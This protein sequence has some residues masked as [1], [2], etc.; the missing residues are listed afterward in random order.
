V[1]RV[2]LA[3]GVLLDPEAEGPR[4]GALLLEDGRIAARLGPG[5]PG[6]GDA[7]RVDLG[8]RLLA[9]GF[10]DLHFHGS[11]VFAD[12]EGFDAA[13]RAD[14]ASLVRGGTTA[15]LVTTVAWERSVLAERV[16][17]LAALVA[18]AG[19]EGARP[20]GLHLEG[21]WLA[22]EA[23]GAQPRDAIRP[24]DPAEGEAVLAA[25][26][27][28]VRAVTF[29]PEIPGADELLAALVRRDVVPALG[30]SL[31]DAD[32]THAAADRG[33]RHV[34]HLWN[35]MG[36][37]HQRAPGLAGAALADDR[38]SCDLVC[39]GAHV[40]PDW[41]RAAIRAKGERLCL[42]SDRVE[43]PA[44]G[45]AASAAEPRAQRGEAERSRSGRGF[46]SGALTDDG[47]AWR[48]PDGRLAGSRLALDRAARNARDFA[49]VPLHAAVAACT[50]APARVLGIESVHGT[51][52]PGARADLAV[53]DAD[54]TL[55]ETWVAGAPAWHRDDAP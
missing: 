20:L 52:R 5:E 19:R 38:L 47:V 22:P 43:P 55:A 36:A 26:A 1:G 41:V 10:V 46:G 37:M 4:P 24:C 34:T 42:I 9:P 25:G 11:V 33:A 18:D 28:L 29:A 53:L 16:E 6:P 35:A 31:A 21:P 48:L 39:D 8:G 7:R 2:L 23:A 15:F 45:M 12:P 44:W 13:L 27:G 54:G 40:H 3:G 14:C 17:R 49:R 30:H 50:L 32:T 51:L